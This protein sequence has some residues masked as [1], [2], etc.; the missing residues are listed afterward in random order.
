M[1]KKDYTSAVAKEALLRDYKGCGE[2]RWFGYEDV[3]GVGSCMKQRGLG[4]FDDLRFCDQPV[5]ED[6]EEKNGLTSNI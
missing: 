6:F 4:C 2:C 3:Y 5:C 1:G